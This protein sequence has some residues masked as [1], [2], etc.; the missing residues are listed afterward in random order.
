MAMHKVTLVPLKETVEVDSEKDLFSQLRK[1]GY[2][3][4]TTC[5]GCASCARCIVVVLEGKENLSEPTFEEK[6]LL[7]NVF[8]ITGE[9]LS[10]QTKI[11]GDI[12]LDISSHLGINEVAKP[13]TVRKSKEQVEGERQ[14]RFEEREKQKQET[15]TLIKKHPHNKDF[16]RMK[17]LGGSKRPKSFHYRNPTED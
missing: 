6:Q 10:C 8:H 17:K 16:G 11:H 15:E 2:P 4:Q 7:G 5:G 14:K 12:T 13:K 3:I 1:M 9:R